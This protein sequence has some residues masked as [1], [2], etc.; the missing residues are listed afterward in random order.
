MEAHGSSCSECNDL[1]GKPTG[2]VQV[3]VVTGFGNGYK[4]R[5]REARVKLPARIDRNRA[6]QR[7]VNL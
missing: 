5:V 7:A 1:L 4:T 6:V 3:D 2:G